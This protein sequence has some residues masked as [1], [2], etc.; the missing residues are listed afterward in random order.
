[1]GISERLHKARIADRRLHGRP[2]RANE[3]PPAQ[4][5]EAST[6]AIDASVACLAPI[7]GVQP[8]PLRLSGDVS[9]G[10]PSRRRM[11]TPLGISVEARAHLVLLEVLDVAIRMLDTPQGHVI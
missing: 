3:D 1:M 6:G 2:V 4:R 9:L 10:L 5:I 11:R 8:K 7:G